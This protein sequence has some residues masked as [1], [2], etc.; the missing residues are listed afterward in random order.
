[1][2]CLSVLKQKLIS[3][4]G[5]KCILFIHSVQ[6]FIIV[7]SKVP[8][9]NDILRI[10]SFGHCIDVREFTYSSQIWTPGKWESVPLT[11]AMQRI[12]VPPIVTT[13]LVAG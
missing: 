3:C 6:R 11:S 7:E 5:L 13:P 2:T 4:I 1:M 9:V 10:E 12:L 8:R